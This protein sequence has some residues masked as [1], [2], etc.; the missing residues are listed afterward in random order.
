MLWRLGMPSIRAAAK[1]SSFGA[2]A[3]AAS[4]GNSSH[5][6]TEYLTRAYNRKSGGSFFFLISVSLKMSGQCG[7]HTPSVSPLIYNTFTLYVH[8]KV[9]VHYAVSYTY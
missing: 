6:D 8:Y 7:I 1:M 9:A 3:A 4:M 2:V 5:Q